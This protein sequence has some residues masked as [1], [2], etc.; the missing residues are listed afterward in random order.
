M[1]EQNQRALEMLKTALS[2]E[3]KGEDF[4]RK[5]MQDARDA[6]GK[7]I[8]ET[9]MRDEKVHYGRIL[10]IYDKLKDEST[11]TDEWKSMDVGHKDV[12]EL[13]REMA[14]KHGKTIEADPG[15]LEALD[16]GIDFE[17]KTMKFYQ[18][19]LSEATDP[20]EKEFVEK[21]V[22]EER[23]HY[24]A[25]KDMKHYMSDPAAWYQEMERGG[26]DGA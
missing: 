19:Y 22:E 2:M 20:L 17:Y 14:A 25:L 5:A 21:M 6:L 26:L 3:E 13:F 24:T 12:T 15:E 4:Y 7:G 9:L 1:A 8:F 23:G 10:K 11:W 18:D 16:V